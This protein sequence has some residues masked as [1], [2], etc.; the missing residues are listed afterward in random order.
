MLETGK[1]KRQNATRDSKKECTIQKK[2]ETNSFLE[3]LFFQTPIA[4]NF[5]EIKTISAPPSSSTYTTSL[6]AASLDDGTVIVD[7]N[8]IDV[9]QQH[10]PLEKKE[11]LHYGEKCGPNERVIQVARYGRIYKRKAPNGIG[12]RAECFKAPP[13]KRFCKM[14]GGFL[15]LDA[16]YTSVKRF[17]CRY[18]HHW[19]VRQTQIRRKE[20]KEK[21][22]VYL[23]KRLQWMGYEHVSFDVID[24]DSIVK[25]ASIPAFLKPVIVPIDPSR[26]MRPRNVAV[27]SSYT[28]QIIFQTFQVTLS[29]ALYVTSVQRSNLLPP[30]FDTGWPDD[31][32]HDPAYRRCDLDAGE[33]FASENNAKDA[34]GNQIW[35]PETVD[36][37]ILQNYGHN[38]PAW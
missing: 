24:M 31:P 34:N 12:P 4:S 32:W 6:P 27:V 21:L 19:R 37:D 36:H 2:K 23:T 25:H 14:C 13:G 15:P 10:V 3:S 33:L 29:R 28:Y 35:P 9:Q 1:G 16:F 30:N 7:A 38:F 26:P 18:H 8:K 22:W 20:P 17:V 11:I 5:G